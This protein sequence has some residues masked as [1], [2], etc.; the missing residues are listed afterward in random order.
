VATSLP[1]TTQWFKWLVDDLRPTPGRFE[2]SLR[3]VL[4]VTVAL[5]LM[6]ALQMP[7]VS[8]GLYIIFVLARQS[9]AVSLRSAVLTVIVA[10]VSVVLELAVVIATDNDPMAR[11]LSVAAITFVA[12]VLTQAS[13][14]APLAP[15]LGFLYCTVIAL[16]ETQRP[17]DAIVKNSLYLIG[18]VALVLGCGVLIEY[19]LASRS[20]VDQLLQE[21]KTRYRALE[22]MFR[23]YAHG[24][25]REELFAA[26]LPVARLAL[27]GQRGMQELYNVIV[28]RNLDPKSLPIGTRVRVTLQAELV[29][30]SAAFATANPSRADSELRER[31]AWIADRCRELEIDSGTQF[32]LEA[33]S[34]VLSLRRVEETLGTLMAMPINS[35]DAVDKKLIVLPTAKV[36]FFL[37]GAL[38]AR[39]TLLFGLKISFCATLCYVAYHALDYPGISTAVTTVLVAGLTST[40]AMKQKLAHRVAGSI[41]GGPILGLGSVVFLL[42]FMDSITPLC[43]LVAIVAFIAAWCA[44]GRR[45]G[46]VGLQIAFSF[47]TVTLATSRAPS[48]LAPARD[49]LI[50]IGLALVVMWFVFDQIWPVR[51]VSMMRQSLARVLRGE[52]QL[53][54]LAG[55]AIESGVL[56]SRIDTLRHSVSATITELRTLH[57]AILYEFGVDHEA[58]KAAGETILRAAL[59]SSALFWNELAVLERSEDRDLRSNPRLL[60]VRS[61]LSTRLDDLAESVEKDRPIESNVAEGLAELQR[62]LDPREAEYVSTMISRYKDMESILETLHPDRPQPYLQQEHGNG[63]R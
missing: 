9:P 45:F 4:T 24:A 41:V 2:S 26:Y 22:A 11:L 10:S 27:A 40:G 32:S 20:A 47:F 49:R 19:L 60:A 5:I 25:S 17:A 48:E 54:K 14:F 53:F 3:I 62:L 36:P 34:R 16:W 55:S 38:G 23:A 51:T 58:H 7:F 18:V 46:Y 15:T 39:T 63:H 35:G 57:E 37:P 52:A 12:G 13:S 61:T 28:Q 8:L 31:C 44:A 33:K 30:V 43:V 50:G 42:P 56:A 6:L 21:R 1:A 59:S 29:D